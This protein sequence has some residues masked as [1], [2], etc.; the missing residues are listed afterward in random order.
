M[1]LRPGRCCGGVTS[2]W[3]TFT[4]RDDGRLLQLENLARASGLTRRATANDKGALCTRGAL[5]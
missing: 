2:G 5:L 4:G 1:E 3:D